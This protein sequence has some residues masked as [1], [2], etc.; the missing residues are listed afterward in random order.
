MPAEHPELSAV[1]DSIA[2][3]GPGAG[4]R[5][6]AEHALEFYN[7]RYSDY[8]PKVLASEV[9]RCRSLLMAHDSRDIRRVL[10]WLSALLGNLAHH[11]GDTA[12]A[13]IHLGTAARLGEQAGDIH[14]SGWAL[15]AQSMVT[16]GQDRAIEALELADQAAAYA[17]TPLR[18]AQITA[19]CRLRPFAALGDRDRLAQAVTSARRHMDTAIEESGRFGFDRAEFEL[20]LAE[21]VLGSDPAGAARHAENSAALKR[22]G[23]PGWAAAT[24][25]L[26]RSHA[27]SRDG[28]SATGLGWHLLEAVPTERI[29]ET[30]RIRLRFLVSDLEGYPE[31]AALREAVEARG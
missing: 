13:L 1:A 4:V 20:H 26:A 5:D 19:W 23:S 24:A 31:A 22:V 15:G 3:N 9:A 11:T 18:R 29:R 25:V 10:G 27:A 21:A 12:G 2:L 7:L 28:E 14:L 17:D 8:P 16:M 30:T 6:L